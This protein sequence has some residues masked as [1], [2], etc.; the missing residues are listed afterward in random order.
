[1]ALLNAFRISTRIYTLAAVQL[2]LMLLVGGVAWSQMQKIGIELVDIAE[3]DI[4]ITNS[5]TQITEHQL[6]QAVL[7]ERALAYGLANESGIDTGRQLNQIVTDFKTLA[8]KVEQEFA[9]TEERVSHAIVTTH[10]QAAASEFRRLLETL[11][12]IDRKHNRY[13]QMALVLLQQLQ[14]G[15]ASA[16]FR[17]SAEVIALED[18]IDHALVEA[19]N[20]IQGFTLNAARQAEADE[21]AGQQLIGGIL[22]VALL[23]A[24]VLPVIIVRAVT[25][26][27]NNLRNR[28]REIAEGDG[29]LSVRLDET[30]T[31]EL[32]EAAQAFNKL[33][34]K[35]SEM[36]KSISSTSSALC[37]QSDDSIRVMNKTRANVDR[38]QEE[39]EMV[40][41]AVEEMAATVTDVAKSTE[42]AAGLGGVI[43]DRVAEGMGCAIDSQ[44][45]IQKLSTEVTDASAAIQS[46]ARET[47]SI[48]EVLDAIRG[49]AEQTNLLALNAAIEAARA[50]DSGRGFAVVADEVR[51]LAQRT[52]SS[53][54]DI[55]NLLSRLQQEAAKAVETMQQGQLSA[56]S[57]LERATVTAGALEEV[58][59]V[60]EQIADLNTQIASA[61]EQQAMV[62]GEINRN[63][64]RITEVAMETTAGAC[65]TSA[66]SE[67]MSQELTRLN[68]YVG[69]FRV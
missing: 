26:P 3:R 53:T 5:L 22:L 63:L 59:Q 25:N 13:D 36:V 37:V 49:I 1:M 57:C 46:L 40:A 23:L 34:A 38:Q 58:T 65:Q 27:V 2:L 33:M 39:T 69:Q 66:V 64:V 24:V 62:A 29:D 28:L 60:V 4:P 7:F 30:G 6:E 21:R 41:S 50:G 17:R 55:Q 67:E 8:K 61:S 31:D 42:Q 56:D 52:Q 45:I 9:E 35:L 44:Q 16:V 14:A 68:A 18:D 47:N 11:Q 48:G 51:A 32:S 12:K 43:R 19:L 15:E 20:K 10:S 54:Q